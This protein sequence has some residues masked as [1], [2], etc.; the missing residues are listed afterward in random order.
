MYLTGVDF[1]FDVPEKNVFNGKVV[2]E[3]EINHFHPDYRKE[4]EVWG[5]PDLDLQERSF[6]LARKVF[7]RDG[8]RIFN[9][10]RGGK[11]V[12]FPRVDFDSLFVGKQ[13]E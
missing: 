3:G 8:R 13:Y 9:A 7:E 5:L 2:S 6:R 1:S 12:V 10:T 4:G 11:L